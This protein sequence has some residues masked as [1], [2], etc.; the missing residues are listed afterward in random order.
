MADWEYHLVYKQ[1]S[2]IQYQSFQDV[3]ELLDFVIENEQQELFI[4]FGQA[5]DSIYDIFGPDSM[6]ISKLDYINKKRQEEANGEVNV[7]EG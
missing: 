3:N 5:Y 1:D 4:F 6:V 7:E 2:E